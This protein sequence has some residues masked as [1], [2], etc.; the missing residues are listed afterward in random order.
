MQQASALGYLGLV[1]VTLEF[2]PFLRRS[3]EPPPWNNNAFTCC[4]VFPTPVTSLSLQ[5]TRLSHHTSNQSQHLPSALK[6]LH[7]LALLSPKTLS[8]YIFLILLQPHW[9]LFCALNTLR[10]SSARPHPRALAQAVP[11]A[12]HALPPGLHSAGS[13]S[14]LGLCPMSHL[15]RASLDDSMKSYLSRLSRPLNYSSLSVPTPHLL[16]SWHSTPSEISHLLF[17]ALFNC[18]SLP[19]ALVIATRAEVVISSAHHCNSA[20]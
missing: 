8:S 12:G 1:G 10:H 9:P 13:A 11:S 14:Y 7:D 5:W 4:P 18:Q 3:L 6:A 15:P 16:A 20:T 19:P 2:L 17:A